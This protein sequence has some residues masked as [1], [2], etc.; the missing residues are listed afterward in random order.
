MKVNWEKDFSE[1][2]Q[3]NAIQEKSNKS[4]N[5]IHDNDDE[6]EEEEADSAD[7]NIRHEHENQRCTG[8]LRRICQ[9]FAIGAGS[10]MLIGHQFAFRETSRNL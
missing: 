7:E 8:M 2:K 4:K 6:E 3:K 1:R 5:S 9:H 10:Q